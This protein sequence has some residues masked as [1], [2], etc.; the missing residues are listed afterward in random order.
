MN[1]IELV[2]EFL[3]KKNLDG[4]DK[5]LLEKY[6]KAVGN[7][8]DKYKQNEKMIDD[9][10]QTLLNYGFVLVKSKKGIIEHFRKLVVKDERN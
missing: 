8:F 7:M 1:N 3:S 9:M 2:E 6:L 4:I 5:F 10:A